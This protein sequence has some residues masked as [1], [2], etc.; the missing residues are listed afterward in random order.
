MV[1]HIDTVHQIN[2]DVKAFIHDKTIY[3][4][5][6]VTMTQFGTGG[7]DK[8]GIAITLHLIQGFQTSK[9]YSFSMKNTDV[10]VHLLAIPVL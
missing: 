10:L 9:Q 7:D 1:C 5:D 3:A 8:V 6:T 4:M 2:Q